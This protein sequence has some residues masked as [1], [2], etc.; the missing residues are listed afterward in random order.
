MVGLR[1]CA[2]VF[3]IYHKCTACIVEDEKQGSVTFPFPPFA[4]IAANAALYVIADATPRGIVALFTII[5]IIVAVIA[6]MLKS[7]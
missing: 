3:H 2:A 4:M 5:I 7:R 6:V 1:C